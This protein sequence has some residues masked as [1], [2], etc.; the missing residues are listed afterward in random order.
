[1]YLIYLDLNFTKI[2]SNLEYLFVK[3]TMIAL[4]IFICYSCDNSNKEYEVSFPLG[5]F[6]R[7]SNVN[8]IIESDSTTLFYCP[9]NESDVYWEKG[10]VFN[11][12]AVVKD[13]KINLLYR[14]ED[15]SS[16]GIGTRVSRIGLAES[17]DGYT[18]KKRNA[19]IIF[20]DKDMNKKYEWPGGCEDPRVAVTED[21]TFVLFYTSWD[22]KTA[23]ICVA[24][25]TD[26][27]NWEKHG[28]AFEKAYEGRFLNEWSKASSILTYLK[29][30]RL[31][32]KKIN[33]HYFMY[34]G[35]YVIYGATSS[36]LVNWTP[37]LDENNELAVLMSPRKGYFDSVLTECGPPS[38]WTSNGIILLYNGKNDE[39]E[40][41]PKYAKNAYCAGQALFDKNNPAKLI[42]RLDQPFLFP[43][44]DFEKSGQ[45]PDGTVF[46]EG[47]VYFKKKWLIYY[48]CADSKVAVAIYDPFT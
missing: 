17:S 23:R 29:D 11:P 45:Y 2:R 31:V 28:P 25:S 13:D 42:R 48:G 27:I 40:G 18:M 30:D 10:D 8:P 3:I 15:N 37:I 44:E 22:R 26:L 1:M 33:G 32:I 47:L 39:K 14:A 43:E 36:D 41:D 12:G 16:I 34:W 38:I 7:P 46:I 35:E 19:P 6:I 9:M 24:T 4:M 5:E 21:G 20:P